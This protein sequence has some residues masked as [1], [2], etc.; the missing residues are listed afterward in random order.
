MIRAKHSFMR[1]LRML[2]ILLEQNWSG[3]GSMM[4]M[5]ISSSAIGKIPDFNRNAMA[6]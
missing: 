5:A 2:S 4:A 1:L 6:T 3:C